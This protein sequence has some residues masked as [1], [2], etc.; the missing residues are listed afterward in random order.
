MCQARS[1][2]S[3]PRESIP[4]CWRGRGPAA[5]ALSS[6]GPILPVPRVWTKILILC[7]TGLDKMITSGLLASRAGPSRPARQAWEL[8]KIQEPSAARAWQIDHPYSSTVPDIEL[9][10]H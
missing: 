10:D 5:A 6:Q 7:H 3:R 8:E 2:P 1:H 9:D 4:G